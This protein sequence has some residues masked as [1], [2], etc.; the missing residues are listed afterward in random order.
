MTLEIEERKLRKIPP[1]S[2]QT[3]TEYQL[4]LETK[5]NLAK[6]IVD[7][8]FPN[9]SFALECALSVRA[10]LEV[11]GLTQPFSLFLIAPPSAKKTTVLE[12]VKPTGKCYHS[13]KFTPRSF[14]SHVANM[15]NEKLKSVDYIR[16]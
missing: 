4:I 14:V 11:K 7:E 12:L 16:L 13:D 15:T 6:E 1:A 8:Y 3:K 9:K 10:Q 2:T 5:F